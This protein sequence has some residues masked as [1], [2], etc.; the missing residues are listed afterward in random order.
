MWDDYGAQAGNGPVI[1][2]A[3]EALRA[4]TEEQPRTLA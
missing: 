4:S 1:W 3:P 2:R